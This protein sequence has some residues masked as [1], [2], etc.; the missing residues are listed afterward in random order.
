MR[1]ETKDDLHA[2]PTRQIISRASSGG[3]FL[4]LLMWMSACTPVA[5]DE[6]LDAGPILA[7]IGQRC[8]RYPCEDSLLCLDIT[9]GRDAAACF[10]TCAE[11][12]ASCEKGAGSVGTCERAPED[13]NAP[14]EL[15][16]VST[17]SSLA[18]CGNRA[19]ARCDVDSRCLM[20][21]SFSSMSCVRVCSFDD[22]ATCK[23]PGPGCGCEEGEICHSFVIL[24]NGDGTCAPPTLPGDR[25]GVEEDGTLHPCTGGRCLVQSAPYPGVCE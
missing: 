22:P 16:C 21:E 1:M 23:Q 17:V 25:C 13:S 15:V 3:G 10:A 4:V 24:A 2:W 8:T 5:A 12:G 18:G 6:T 14:G 7:A 20:L 11:E 19:N 9:G